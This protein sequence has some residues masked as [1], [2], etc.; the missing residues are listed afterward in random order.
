[1]ITAGG[2]QSNHARQTAAAAARLGLRC[3]L[4]L[5]SN[6]PAAD[7]PDYQESGNMLLDRLL[8]AQVAIHPAASDRPA[9]MAARAEALTGD[10]RRPYIIPIG[11]SYPTG[12]L[13]YVRAALEITA[14]ANDMGVHFDYLVT[15]TSSGGTLAAGRARRRLRGPQLSDQTDRRRRRR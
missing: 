10:G 8:G 15:A 9:L 7:T 5:T 2:L 6:A 4:V 13:G 12:N 14:Q 11:A 1:V 3:E